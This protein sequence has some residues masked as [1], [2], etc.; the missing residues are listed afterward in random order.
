ML[1]PSK[2][3]YRKF[4]KGRRRFKGVEIR[5]V[6]LTH[7]SFGLKALQTKWVKNKQIEAARRAILRYLKKKGK[8][9]IR[10]F[11]QKPITSKGVEFSMG[12]GK[13]D[14]VGYVFPVKKGRIL[15]ELD[16]IEED[17]ARKAFREA[18]DKLPIKTEFVKK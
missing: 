10:I 18:S 2:T 7:G 4:Q 8:L 13:G 9:W 5:G 16:G 14:V 15:F 12:G 6:N 3:K 1:E 17:V 11:P